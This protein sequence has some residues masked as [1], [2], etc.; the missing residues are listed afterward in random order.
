MENIFFNITWLF[1]SGVV[2]VINYLINLMICIE[3]A[4]RPYF[5][6]TEQA[7]K[8]LDLPTFPSRLFRRMKFTQTDGTDEFHNSNIEELFGSIW[9]LRSKI[10]NK[11]PDTVS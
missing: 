5:T 1:L 4:R 10:S 2:W 7:A 6:G 3:P 8:S 11:S 9:S